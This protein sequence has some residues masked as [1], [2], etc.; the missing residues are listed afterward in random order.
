MVTLPY[1]FFGPYWIQL[2]L[3]SLLP[4]ASKPCN[5]LF[6]Q[7]GK[8]YL[9]AVIWGTCLF[10]CAIAHSRAWRDLMGLDKG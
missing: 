7:R 4:V 6:L 1:L 9:L 3:S 10:A 2:L 5:S 8:T